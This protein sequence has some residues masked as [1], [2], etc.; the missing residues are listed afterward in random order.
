MAG[1]FNRRDPDTPGVFAY[2]A[3]TPNGLRIKG[4]KARMTAY[5]LEDVRRELIDQGYTPIKITEV[6][7]SS[8]SASLNGN[9]GRKG[10]KLKPIQTAA[11]ARGLHQLLRAGISVAR[12]VE[13]LGE[14][15]ADED[16]AAMCRDIS[17]KISNGTPVSEAFA[18]HPRTFDDVFC[19]Y[20]AAGE[21]TGSLVVATRRLAELTEK[22]A[23]LSNKIKSVSIYPILVSI[24]IGLLMSGIILFLVPRY[25][26]IYA[27]FNAKLPAPTLAL[28]S[29]SHHFLPISFY[30]FI[31]GPNF[32]SPLFYIIAII[33]GVRAFLRK[34]KDD[35][36]IGTFVDKFRFR[37]PIFGK[38]IHFLAMFR[39]SSTLTGALESG[40]RTSQALSL[41]AT[42]S[43][44]K[45]IKALTPL[46]EAGIQSGRP[47]SAMLNEYP[48]LF[49]ASVRT[50]V[51][52]G[53]TSG[54]LTAMLDSTVA[55]LSDEIDAIVAGLGAKIEVALIV[56]MGLVV[57]SMLVCLYL[58]I[59][60]L[61]ATVTNSANS[62]T[63]T[64]LP[65][66]VVHVP[67][68]IPTTIPPTPIP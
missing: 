62:A 58:P 24:V 9:I 26:S 19:G 60:N 59:I 49:P 23:T 56:F 35:P 67:A 61:A 64:T 2:E 7:A 28:V 66:G 40:V 57:G 5:T 4:P 34:K 54:E 22:R 65:G 39:W 38:L 55:T 11:F 46:F 50:M 37:M 53:E 44:S 32:T 8:L 42:A 18:T 3:I 63:T 30:G 47:L 31:P 13:A 12:A 29:L 21:Q 68:T 51:A 14:D 41:A 52:T 16:M 1:R 43:G 45:W 17:T 33:V 25:Q 36:V 10:L 15:A 6:S 27:Q 20:L 48:T